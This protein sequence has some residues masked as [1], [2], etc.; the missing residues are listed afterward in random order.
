MCYDFLLKLKIN[1]KRNCTFVSHSKFLWLKNQ[2]FYLFY[3]FSLAVC[4]EKNIEPNL[5]NSQKS[6]PV[7]LSLGAGAARKK[8]QEPEPPGKKS[9]AGAA[10]KNE[11]GAG[12]AK[13]LAGSPVLHCSPIT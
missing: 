10:R 7:F 6:E 2:L 4:G 9:G 12:A 5:T 1:K 13:K 3:V 11:S 8:Y